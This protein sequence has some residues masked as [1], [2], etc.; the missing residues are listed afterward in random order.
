MAAATLDVLVRLAMTMG[1][2][3]A[4]REND[5]RESQLA[6]TSRVTSACSDG[7]IIVILRHSQFDDTSAT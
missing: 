1:C 3:D 6:P 4:T 7:V 2:W 5:G